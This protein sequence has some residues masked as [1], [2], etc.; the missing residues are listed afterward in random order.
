M[1]RP[2]N[3]ARYHGQSRVVVA[4]SGGDRLESIAE[5]F[6]GFPELIESP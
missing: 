3:L 2:V 4:R 6:V 5:A 1:I